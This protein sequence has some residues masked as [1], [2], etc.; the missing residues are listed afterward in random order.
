MA[1]KIPVSIVARKIGK[2]IR[3][4]AAGEGFDQD[5][6]AI[7]GEFDEPTERFYLIVG[8]YRPID[9]RRW[10]SGIRK[11]IREEFAEDPGISSYFVLNVR[12]VTR[13]EEVYREMGIG[14]GGIDVTD[15]F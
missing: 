6:F 11:A 9:E 4:F 12:N 7:V 10:H 3:T 8:S 15:L 1:V 13:I 14:D 5:E 2:A